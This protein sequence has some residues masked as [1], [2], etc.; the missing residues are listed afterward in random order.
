[1]LR[2]L[3]AVLPIATGFIAACLALP[4][5][6][7]ILI[8]TYDT[9]GTLRAFADEADGDVAP[10]R[11]IGGPATALASAAGG[12]FEPGEGVLYLADFWGQAVR[13]F[14]AYADGDTAPIRVLGSPQLGQMRTVAIDRTHDELL[15]THSGCCLAAYPRTASGNDFA[16]RVWAWGGS[17]GSQ[18][19]LD[20]PSSLTYAAARDE[21]LLSD[22]DG[23]GAK[24]LVFDRGQTDRYA[25]PKR[26]VQGSLTGLGAW[27]GGIAVD[28]V[29]DLLYAV[30]F[31]ANPDGSR[32]GRILAF[33]ADAGG[34]AAPLRVLAGPSTQLDTTSQGYPLGVAIDAQHRRLIV[35]V[36]NDAAAG[37]ALLV[38]PLG[39]SG[40]I[41][42]LHAIRGAQTGLSNVGLPIWMPSD[43]IFRNG[44]D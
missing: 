37:N 38:F 31:I 30:T 20:Y 33:A 5:R 24:V 4:A 14:P 44:L 21:V 23:N 26:V 36:S 12:S 29:D 43:V 42:P 1:M 15:T 2:T 9:P 27:I 35:S 10:I 6:A 11:L 28:P 34:N 32:S 7:D 39:A 19:G 8:G 16:L 3:A 17:P 41:P 40:D 25:P 18:T 22:T 13:V